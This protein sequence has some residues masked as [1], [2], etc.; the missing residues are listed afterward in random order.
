VPHAWTA[1][2]YGVKVQLTEPDDKSGLLPPDEI[3]RIQQITG[4]LL[5]YARAVDATMLVFLGTIAAQQS[6]ATIAT[7]QAVL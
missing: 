4:T 2:N 1:P 6:K 5:Y 7:S 3:K